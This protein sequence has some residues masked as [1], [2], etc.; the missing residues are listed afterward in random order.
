MVILDWR[1][2]EQ[3]RIWIGKKKSGFKQVLFPIPKNAKKN[4]K[5]PNWELQTNPPELA[6]PGKHQIF[7]SVL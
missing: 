5:R 4:A 2:K 6:R 3:I 1:T 7:K